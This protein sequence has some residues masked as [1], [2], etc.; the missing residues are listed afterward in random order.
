[1]GQLVDYKGR[2]LNHVEMLYQPGERSLAVAAADAGK[3]P[4]QTPIYRPGHDRRRS[5][6]NGGRD[7]SVPASAQHGYKA[8][9]L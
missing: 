4:P 9:I 8:G 7:G 3:P 1:M 6:P 2:M 5:P